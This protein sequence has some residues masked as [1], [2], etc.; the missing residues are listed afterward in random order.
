[1]SRSDCTVFSHHHYTT[2]SAGRPPNR[3]L[4]PSG[5][6]AGGRSH[7]D[8]GILQHTAET[9]HLVTL[10][11][12]KVYHIVITRQVVAHYV[13]FDM[14]AVLGSYLHAALLIH[15][16]NNEIIAESMV[17]NGLPVSLGGVALARHGFVQ[18]V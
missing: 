6:L 7:A 5:Y 11:V 17:A 13:I 18:I 16:V 9:T 1:M 4:R 2:H 10:E 15:Q 14:L 3:W 12:G 8:G